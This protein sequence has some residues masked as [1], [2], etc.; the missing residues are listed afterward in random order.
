M[1]VGKPFAC[2]NRQNYT[3]IDNLWCFLSLKLKYNNELLKVWRVY[4]WSWRYGYSFSSFKEKFLTFLSN[5]EIKSYKELITISHQFVFTTKSS[6]NKNMPN[7]NHF[8]VN[9]LVLYYWEFTTREHIFKGWVC[10]QKRSSNI[11]ITSEL[12]LVKC[13]SFLQLQG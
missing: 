11:S 9:W 6:L 8:H 2:Y 10:T 1:E 7:Y 5:Q 3:I 13:A 12:S 4:F